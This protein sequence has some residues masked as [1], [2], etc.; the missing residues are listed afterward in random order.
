MCVVFMVVLHPDSLIMQGV[1]LSIVMTIHSD[2]MRCSPVGASP[3]TGPGP[4]ASVRVRL[5]N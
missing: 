3:E 5:C 2:I 4:K 1:D